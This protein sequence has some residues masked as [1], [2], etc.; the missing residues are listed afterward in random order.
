MKYDINKLTLEEK[1]GQLFMFGFDATEINDHAL[2][3]IKDYRMGNVILFARNIKTPE[4]VFKLNQNLQKLA[5]EELGV[6]LFISIDQEGGMVSRITSGATFFPGAMTLSATNDV[7]HAY[8]SGKYMGLELINL[9]INMNFA[10]VLDVNNNPK[11][12]VIGV[13]SFSDQPDRVAAYGEAFIKGMQENVIATGKHF[14]GHGDTHVDSHL[15]LPKVAYGMDRLNAVE[16]VPFKHAIKKGI[17]AMMSS[18]IDFPALTENGLPTTLSKKC[19]TGF[20]REE[21]GFEGLIVTD[22]MQMKAIQDNYTTVKAS[23][24]AIEAGA[25]IVCICHSEE[26]QMKAIDYMKES[27]LS[28]KISIE[29]INERVSRVLKFKE[30]LK[31]I[32]LNQSYKSV[33][34]VVE[35]QKT[36]DFS[37]QVVRKALTLVK[38]KTLDLKDNALFIGALPIATSIADESDGGY[39]IISKIRKEL[40]YLDTMSLPIQ[41][42]KDEM[43]MII[44]AAK[45]HDQVIL[46]TYNA[47]IYQEQIELITK[48][49]KLDVELHVI[50]MRNPYDLHYAKDIKNYVCLYEYTPNSLKVLLEYLKKELVPEGTIP[51]TYE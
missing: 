28:G 33:K 35:N 11:N 40:P 4:Q 32:D 5:A 47:N 25:N 19:M 37:Y 1:I 31:E 30:E 14:P 8:L 2:K 3:L 29:T 49:T 44:D 22:G 23:L 41:P 21:L 15:A 27:V 34:D 16:L 36:K 39:S 48:L 17:K 38:G 51:V 10:P 6:P 45:G 43:D 20:L 18:H 46:C 50:S 42:T 9:G 26:L 12:P 13:R 7:N 24:M